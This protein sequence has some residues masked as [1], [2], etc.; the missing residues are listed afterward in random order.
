MI[1]AAL[2]AAAT[3]SAAAAPTAVAP[4]A[5]AP[6]VATTAQ[7]AKSSPSRYAIRYDQKS[8]RYCLRERNGTPSTGSHIVLERCKTRSDW[9]ADGLNLAQR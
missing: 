6:S 8:D 1:I 4:S 9:A 3:L 2:L 7:P 5:V